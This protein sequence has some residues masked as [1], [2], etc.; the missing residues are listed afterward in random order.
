[1]YLVGLINQFNDNTFRYNTYLGLKIQDLCLFCLKGYNIKL[2]R[3][4]S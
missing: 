4:L 3:I 2:N 1:M